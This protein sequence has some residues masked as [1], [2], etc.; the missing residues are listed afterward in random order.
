[1]DLQRVHQVGAH[2]QPEDDHSQHPGEEAG[3]PA[4]DTTK[5]GYL[6]ITKDREREFSPLTVLEC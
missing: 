2:V 3:R 1:M 6:H 5:Y 4:E